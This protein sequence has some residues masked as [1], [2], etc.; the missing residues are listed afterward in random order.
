[1]D[2]SNII[3]DD[4]E[5][6]IGF[7]KDL[8]AMLKSAMIDAIKADRYLEV[9][10]PEAVDLLDDLEKFKS[11]DGLLVL[12]ENNG[13]VYTITPYKAPEYKEDLNN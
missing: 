10:T 3:T 1:M 8:K 5:Q 9:I 11:Y 2:D 4:L 7:Y 13:M 6:K 12:S